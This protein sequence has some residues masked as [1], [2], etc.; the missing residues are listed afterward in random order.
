MKSQSLKLNIN[1]GLLLSG[2]SSMFSGILIQVEYHFGNHFG[3]TVNK[4]VFGLSYSGWSTIHKISIVV[5]SLFVIY[6]VYQHLKWYK[7]II[8]K[9]LFAK[10]QQVLIFSI[11]F[12]MV[13][14]TGLIPWFTDLL[15]GDEMQRKA[16]IEI[17]DKIALILAIYL[18]FHVIKRLKWFLNAFKQYE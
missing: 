13:A 9:R 16:I 10:N 12:V 4:T 18:V 6:H 11:L 5:F 1:L 14:I 7:T 2:L 15:N 17:H 3:M 8:A